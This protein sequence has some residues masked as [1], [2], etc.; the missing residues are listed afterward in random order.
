MVAQHCDINDANQTIELIKPELPNEPL[1]P[2]DLTLSE[3]HDYDERDYKLLTEYVEA[4]DTSLIIL[5]CILLA[6][7]LSVLVITLMRNNEKH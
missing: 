3:R 2:A 6:V 7:S 1:K 4:G 5:W